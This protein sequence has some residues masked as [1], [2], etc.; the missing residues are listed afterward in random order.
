MYLNNKKKLKIDYYV[1]K[2][3]VKSFRY[4]VSDHSYDKN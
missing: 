2:V 1:E 4:Q 3:H